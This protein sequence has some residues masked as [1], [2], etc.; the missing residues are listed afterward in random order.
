MAKKKKKQPRFVDATAELTGGLSGSTIVGETGPE[1]VE[2]KKP[3]RIF[4][5]NQIRWTLGLFYRR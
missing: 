2:F 4:N 5:M 1:I 3:S